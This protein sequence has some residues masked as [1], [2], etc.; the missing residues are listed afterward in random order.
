MPCM[1]GWTATQEIFKKYP[2]ERRPDIIAMTAYAYEH[3]QQRCA[4]LGMKGM[5]TTII[6]IVIIIL[7]ML[8]CADLRTM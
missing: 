2:P 1:D 3:D 8:K 6:I 5:I 4:Q 7:F